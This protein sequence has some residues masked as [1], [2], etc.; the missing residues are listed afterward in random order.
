[1]HQRWIM[2]L[3]CII[4]EPLTPLLMRTMKRRRRRFW[5]TENV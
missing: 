2:V 3:L 5:I 1:M 4:T